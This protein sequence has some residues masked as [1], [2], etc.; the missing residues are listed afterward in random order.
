MLKMIVMT[1]Y[2]INRVGLDVKQSGG[3]FKVVYERGEVRNNMQCHVIRATGMLILRMQTS[4]QNGGHPH[5]S[6]PHASNTHTHTHTHTREACTGDRVCSDI[7][8]IEV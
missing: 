1:Q 4:R 5:T 6:P 2:W 3:G 8:R 7:S